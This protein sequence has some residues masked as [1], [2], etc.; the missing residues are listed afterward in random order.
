MP[1]LA[2]ALEDSALDMFA[3]FSKFVEGPARDARRVFT[4]FR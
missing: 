4:G 2:A 1:L 3:L